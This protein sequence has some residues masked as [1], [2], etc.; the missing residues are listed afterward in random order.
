MR[1][2]GLQGKRTALLS[3]GRKVTAERFS[4]S[5]AWPNR[6]EEWSHGHPEPRGRFKAQR[7]VL[8]T[9]AT[10]TADGVSARTPDDLS[11]VNSAA[12]EEKTA[13]APIF[14]IGWK[15]VVNV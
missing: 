14:G 3:F 8:A 11:H 13:T 4:F 5:M 9:V 10:D 7:I 6:I 15:H 2:A 1:G 12:S